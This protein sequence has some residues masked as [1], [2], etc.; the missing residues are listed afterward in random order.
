MILTAAGLTLALAAVGRIRPTPRR[1]L[2]GAPS[3]V[4]GME[5]QNE[6]TAF[7]DQFSDNFRVIMRENIRV[8]A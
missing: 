4:F 1:F 5:I 7:R 6:W 2:C 3:S 8:L